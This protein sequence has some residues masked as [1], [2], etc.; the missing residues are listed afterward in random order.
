MVA[1]DDGNVTVRLITVRDYALIIANPQPDVAAMLEGLLVYMMEL[2]LKLRLDRLDGI[3]R[4]ACH[5]RNV[6]PAICEGFFEGLSSAA[7]THGL[8][9]DFDETVKEFIALHDAEQLHAVA[10]SVL[11]T[12]S[13]KAGERDLLQRKL[14]RHIA[15]LR[16]TVTP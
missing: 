14:K 2:S 11:K 9:A 8:P 5:N 6:V 13:V 16:N 7:P 15:I 12:T 1:I 10:V 4:M 3:D